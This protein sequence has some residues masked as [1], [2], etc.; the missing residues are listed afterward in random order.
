MRKYFYGLLC[1]L[2]SVSLYFILKPNPAKVETASITR[3]LFLETLSS[4]GKVRSKN[5]QIV[6]AMATGNITGVRA[7]VGDEVKKSEVLSRLDWDF[8][9][10]IK[11]PIDGVLTKVYRES[12]GP[13]LR[14]EP[15][16][17][18]SNLSELEVVVDLL[19]PDAVRL[20]KN[21][22]AKILNWGKQ[23]ELAAKVAQISRAGT[24]KTSAL[25]VEEER[26]E[27]RLSLDNIPK[28]LAE[29]FGDNFHVDVLFVISKEDQV[30]TV[31]LGALFQT[32]EDWS[33]YAV[34]DG[35]AKAKNIKISKR[36]DKQA[37]VSEGLVEGDLV[38]LFPGDKI[39]DGSMVRE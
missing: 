34:V 4:E 31:P 19:T 14:G 25:G 33:V 27:V 12:S 22:E 21:T 16:F 26:T 30:L 29:T 2:I 35:R 9:Q 39:R 1:L 3:G 15:I 36:N 20:G 11:S 6:Y 38:I 24:V 17:E 32:G 7:K 5:K 28:E 10:E 8:K 23:S 37:V 13:I 18:V